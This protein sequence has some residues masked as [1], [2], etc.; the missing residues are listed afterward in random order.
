MNNIIKTTIYS[1]ATCA[2][3]FSLQGCGSDRAGI[4]PTEAQALGND[5]FDDREVKPADQDGDGIDDA[6]EIAGWTDSCGNTYTTDPTKW[7]S[8]GD[9][10]KDGDEMKYCTNP[11]VADTDGD[12]L[13]DR[14][15]V[16]VNVGYSKVTDPTNPDS[17]NDGLNDGEEVN[18]QLPTDP[19]NPDSDGDMLSDGVEVKSAGTDPLKPDTDNDG[20][21]DG[22]EVCGTQ[23][24]HHD[25]TGKIDQTDGGIT[26]L[27]VDNES[28]TNPDFYNDKLN[29]LIIATDQ[30]SINSCNITTSTKN[31]AVVSTND[32]D[33]DGRPNYLEYDAQF[34]TDTLHQ[35]LAFADTNLSQDAQN[36]IDK[37]YYYPW[38]TQTSDGDKM[39]QANFVYVPKSDSK[40]FWISKYEAVYQDANKDSVVF[41]NAN[42]KVDYVNIDTENNG[43]S[44]VVDLLSNSKVDGQLNISL[45]TRSQYTDLMTFST[46]NQSSDCLT[47]INN[48]GDINMPK[49]ASYDVC[50]IL[51]TTTGATNVE[52]KSDGK[53]IIQSDRTFIED[54]S[55]EG[56]Q[57][58]HFRA[59]A[60][61]DY[62]K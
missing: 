36:D 25:N 27:D 60:Q 24:H 33:G 13:D 52:F 16:D 14:D 21:N 28:E 48:V 44:S 41:T 22:I 30:N 10:L 5:S 55:K 49:D 59:A 3:L 42:D 12:G 50:E 53:V 7:S 8:D 31:D 51:P 1:L 39:V 54:S 19:N 35:G 26:I 32:S 18:R 15:E 17:D 40:G 11:H 62:I 4:T 45:P 9:N 2:I 38:I 57:N 6:D 37:K 43:N 23:T 58:T 47:I 34:K 46:S 61:A 56:D 29:T 20:V